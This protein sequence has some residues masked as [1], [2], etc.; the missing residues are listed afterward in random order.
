MVRRRGFTLV[1]LLVVIAIIAILMGLL[2]PAVQKV[3]EVAARTSTMNNGKQCTLGFHMYHDANGKL[4]PA[5]GWNGNPGASAQGTPF[6]TLLPFIEQD[7]L[8]KGCTNAGQPGVYFPGFT[9][10][11]GVVGAFH[12]IKPYQSTLD[13]GITPEGFSRFATQWGAVSFAYNFQVFGSMNSQTGQLQNCNSKRTFD[14]IRDGTSNTLMLAEKYSAC[15]AGGTQG[16][17]LWGQSYDPA[18]FAGGGLADFYEPVFAYPWSANYIG[19]VNAQGQISFIGANVKFQ[20]QPLPYNS[21]ACDPRMA[22]SSRLT[23]IIVTLC[24]GSTRLVS[25]SVSPTTWWEVC[26]PSGGET[27]GTDW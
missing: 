6:F 12:A 1:E 21:A 4:P 17:S 25:A 26:T 24:D 13:P 23:G 7:N 19:K 10:P 27:L 3:R 14:D 16:G 2:L 9:C 20:V 8:F 11:D 15:G 22:Q 18:T 5:Q